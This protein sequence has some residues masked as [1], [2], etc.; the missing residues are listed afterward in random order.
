L[1]GPKEALQTLFKSSFP[2]LIFEALGSKNAR[3]LHFWWKLSYTVDV[4]HPL[5]SPFF[6]CVSQWRRHRKPAW[7]YYLFPVGNYQNICEKYDQIVENKSRRKITFF[8]WN[9]NFLTLKPKFLIFFLS[10]CNNLNYTEPHSALKTQNRTFELIIWI[11][12][13]REKVF[14]D[15]RFT[16]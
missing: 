12:I 14:N 7:I 4:V 16:I 8:T 11:N 15:P 3:L 13:R 2:S 9:N 6:S 10:A 1:R 5:M